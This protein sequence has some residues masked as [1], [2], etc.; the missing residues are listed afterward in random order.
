MSNTYASVHKIRLACDK[1]VEDSIL[2]EE[3]RREKHIQEI[4]S[5]PRRTIGEYFLGC[6]NKPAK[7]RE[8][9]IEIMKE[10]SHWNPYDLKAYW[11][12]RQV[13]PILALCA[14]AE[15]SHQTFI[16][17]DHDHAIIVKPYLPEILNATL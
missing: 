15:N 6:N 2:S 4:L 8:M 16:T 1:Y 3:K 7:T 9:A 5:R 17:L 10:E 14:V 11:P 12:K 13:E